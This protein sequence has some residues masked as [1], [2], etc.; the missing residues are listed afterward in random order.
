MDTQQDSGET[1]MSKDKYGI[2][3]DYYVK[4]FIKYNAF[5]QRPLVISSLC[6]I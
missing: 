5:G 6:Q 1:I 4:Y 2:S 3:K